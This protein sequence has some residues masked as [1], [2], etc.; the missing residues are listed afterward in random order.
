MRKASWIRASESTFLRPALYLGYFYS[1]AVRYNRRNRGNPVYM[2]DGLATLHQPRFRNDPAFVAA[3]QKAIDLGLAVAANIE[4]RAHT[5]CW[6]ASLAMQRPGDFA[7]CGVCRGFLSHIVMEYVGFAHTPKRFYLLDTYEG[8][9]VED[10][11]SA[12][13]K[14]RAQSNPD[15]YKG[16]L[17]IVTQTFKDFSNV[18]IVPGRVPGTLSQVDSRE[19]AFVHIDMNLAEPEIAAAEFF[20]ERLVSGGFMIMDDYGHRPHQD[21]TDAFD[22]FAKKRNVRIL[23]LPTGQGL[24]QKA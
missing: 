12:V 2:Q 6:A 9:A 18:R 13:E 5:L 4:W 20:W 11:R 8:L 7:E 22:A 24:I 1:K 16:N 10:A 17:S 21:Q 3:Y 19:F 15:R 14:A 23:A